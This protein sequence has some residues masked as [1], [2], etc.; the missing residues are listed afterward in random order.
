[1]PIIGPDATPVPSSGCDSWI[2][3]A[4][5]PCTQLV[6]DAAAG[7]PEDVCALA[8]ERLWARTG[9]RFGPSC[10]VTIRPCDSSWCDG[11]LSSRL[12]LLPFYFLRTLAGSRC[13]PWGATVDLTTLG[14]IYDVPAVTIDGAPFTDFRLDDGRHLLRL[15]GH[16]WPRYQDVEADPTAADTFA[17]TVRPGEPIPPGGIRAA[18]L[19][20]CAL[21]KARVP[22]LCK[23]NARATTV[24]RQG[25]T[26]ELEAL[27]SGRIGILEVDAFLDDWNPH[28]LLERSSC[29]SPDVPRHRVTP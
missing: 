27:A 7:D 17:V 16:P 24:A 29:W 10:P 13:N 3:P 28:G 26:V 19:L 22:A 8:S 23:P 18:K 1:M 11:T 20:A 9:R 2:A 4:D 6:A 21:L 15:D 25:V 14:P 12:N 5:L